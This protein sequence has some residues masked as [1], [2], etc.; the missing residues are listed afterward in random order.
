M[1]QSSALRKFLRGV[2][3]VKTLRA[4]A[5]AFENDGAYVFSTEVETRTP[6][7]LIYR[8]YAVERKP[9]PDHW[10]LLAGEAIHNIRAS[11]DH[12]VYAATGDDDSAFPICTDAAKF[13]RRSKGCLKGIPATMRTTIENAQPYITTPSAPTQDLLELLRTLSNIDKHRTLATLASSV[14][15]EWIGLSDD[16]EITWNEAA[17]NK[18]LTN[19]KTHI[20]TF[21]ATSEREIREVDVQ[22]HFAYEVRIEGRPLGMLTSIARKVFRVLAEC[23]TGKPLSP[24]APYPI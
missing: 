20:S 18:V 10:P 15:H 13:K 14:L 5:D 19:E 3:Q 16:I 1:T 11:L 2:E 8:C 24:F 22:P 7:H 17:T 4:E 12:V 21:T 6:K 23:E 9:V